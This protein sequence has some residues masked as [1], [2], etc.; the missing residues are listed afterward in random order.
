MKLAK[1]VGF[2]RL[3]FKAH[4]ACE[5]VDEE[6][7]QEQEEYIIISFIRNTMKH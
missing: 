4:L 6:Q 2:Q 3:D 1:I 7:E 5:I